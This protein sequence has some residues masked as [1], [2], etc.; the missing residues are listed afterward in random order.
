MKKN[1]SPQSLIEQYINAGI[2]M[3]EAL[4]NG[5]Y[6]TNNREAK[7]LKKIK[8]DFLENN[9]DL[10]KQVFAEVMKSENDKARSIA[11]ADALRLNIL[12]EQAI[13]VLE[14]VAK[15]ADIIGF[16]AETSL[17]IWRGEYPGKTL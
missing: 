4:P 2:I 14:D 9:L 8:T 5:D 12:I 15:R 11:A 1:I 16:G 10:A 13:D 6:K 7:K 17:K 3:T